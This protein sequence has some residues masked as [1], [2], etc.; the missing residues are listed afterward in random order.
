MDA[1]RTLTLIYFY[2]ENKLMGMAISYNVNEGDQVIGALAHGTYFFVFADPGR[3]TYSATTEATS[4]RTLEV[5]GGK[6]YYIEASVE[7]GVLAGHP[8]LRI[9][10]QDEAK[11]VLQTCTYAIK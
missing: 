11:S 10:N 2:R 8:A 5:E 1:D 6:T 3:H 4:S 9:A 7:L